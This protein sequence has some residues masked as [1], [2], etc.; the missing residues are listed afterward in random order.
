[1]PP[2]L[3]KNQAIVLDV[4]TRSRRPMKAYEILEQL[5]PHG[6]SGP[7]TVYRALEALQAA[8]AIHRI[9]SIN[10]FVACHHHGHDSGSPS[11]VLCR[12]CGTVEEIHDVRLDQLLEEWSE[13]RKF[14]VTRAVMEVQGLCARCHPPAP[15]TV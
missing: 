3:R 2:A 14:T 15:M 13:A 10:A 7:P 12:K 9:D 6:I 5:A 8:G 1:M 11:F 4:L